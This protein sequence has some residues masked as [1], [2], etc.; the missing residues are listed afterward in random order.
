[1][2]D[3]H[4]VWILVNLALVAVGLGDRV[5]GHLVERALEP[6]PGR[7]AVNSFQFTLG[8]TDHALGLLAELRGDLPAAATRL[9][10]AV[11]ENRCMGLP[12]PLARS[13]LELARV[14]RLSGEGEAARQHLGA[15][16]Q[17]AVKYGLKPLIERARAL[18]A[19]DGTPPLVV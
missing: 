1:E 18:R 12:V 5:R 9:R 8:A 6:F 16:E 11:L 14:L 10:Q 19:G 17:L 13:E 15:G 7:S 4:H 3:Y 2:P